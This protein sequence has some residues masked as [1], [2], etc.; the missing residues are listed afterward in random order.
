MHVCVCET[1]P[2]T[3]PT[4]FAGEQEK[5]WDSFQP[6]NLD[7]FILNS[8]VDYFLCQEKCCGDCSSCPWAWKAEPIPNIIGGI[9]RSTCPALSPILRCLSTD[10]H[11]L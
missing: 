8:S 3:P 10:Y 4:A 11:R 9:N 2:C 1:V 5:S 7:L 6:Y